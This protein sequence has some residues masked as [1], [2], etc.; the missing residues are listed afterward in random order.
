MCCPMKIVSIY[1]GHILLLISQAT[2]G[3]PI[4]IFLCL[5]APPCPLEASLPPR[6]AQVLSGNE[7]SPPRLEAYTSSDHAQLGLVHCL[8]KINHK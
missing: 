2:S 6:H 8:H 4:S 1:L 3:C 5:L 7:Q